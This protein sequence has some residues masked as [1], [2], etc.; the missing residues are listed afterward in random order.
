MKCKE[1]NRIMER[2]EIQNGL[3]S[4]ERVR[5]LCEPCGKVF[6]KAFKDG[7]MIK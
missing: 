7:G 6:T 5:Y 2:L 4:R 1:C 3:G